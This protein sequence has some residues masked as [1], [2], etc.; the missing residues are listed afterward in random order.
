MLL[1]IS[2]MFEKWTKRFANKATDGA[3]EGMKEALNDKIDR[4]GDIIQLGLVIAVIAFGGKHLVRRQETPRVY[5]Y[6]QQLR[7]PSYTGQ[8]IIINNYYHD[9]RREEMLKNGTQY[10]TRK[11][12]QKH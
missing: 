8:P 1:R 5:P 2:F 4:Y 7:I 3:V 9:P 12:H 6:P 11:N 10:Q